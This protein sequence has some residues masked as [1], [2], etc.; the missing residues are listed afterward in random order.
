ML[1]PKLKSNSNATAA[2]AM[3][4]ITLTACRHSAPPPPAAPKKIAYNETYDKEI[5][6]VMDLAGKDRW[7]EAEV[8]AAALQQRDPKNPMLERIHTWVMQAGQKRREQ[9]LENKIRDIDSKNSVFSQTAKS[10]LTDKRDQGL[11]A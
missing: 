3:L 9:A 4:L 8:K 11:P 5:R 6:E 1:R 10:L 2:I 7:E